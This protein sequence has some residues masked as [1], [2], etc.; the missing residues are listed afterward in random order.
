MHACIPPHQRPHPALASYLH[1]LQ[2]CLIKLYILVYFVYSGAANTEP[3][4]AII[5]VSVTSATRAF[6]RHEGFQGGVKKPRVY[7]FDMV[8]MLVVETF[9]T[10]L[11]GAIKYRA[12]HLDSMLSVC[13]S[14][15]DLEGYKRQ[16]ISVTGHV[17]VDLVYGISEV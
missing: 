11:G 3:L 12:L 15:R 13:P 2:A 6:P 7:L 1:G 10:N 17:A 8:N 9:V 4:S 5:L 14:D 16:S